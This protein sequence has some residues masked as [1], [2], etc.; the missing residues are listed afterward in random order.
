MY[1][2]HKIWKENK[3]TNKTTKI[4]NFNVLNAEKSLNS[5]QKTKNFTQQK[6]TQRQKDALSAAKTEKQETTIQEAADSEKKENSL[7]YAQLADVKP[8]FRLNQ[9]T[10]DLFFVQ[11]AT[12]KDN[13]N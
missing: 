13:N 10:T 12:E 7:L 5:L 11:I 1:L 2:L 9:A 3:C 6:V 8:Q 4:N